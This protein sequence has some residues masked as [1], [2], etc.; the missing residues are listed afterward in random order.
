MQDHQK[1]LTSFSLTEIQEQSG[2]SLKDIQFLADIYAGSSPASLIGWGVQRYRFG[3]ENIRWINALAWQ[4][5]AIGR[6]GSGVY[7][8]VSSNHLLDFSWLGSSTN[9]SF[10][11]PIIGSEIERAEPGIDLAWITCS[12]VVNQAPDSRHVARV[13]ASIE[14][15]VVVDAFLTD[16]A[17]CADLVLPP[18]LMW[19]EEDLVGSCMHHGLQYVAPVVSPPPGARSD[20]WMVKELNHRLKAPVHLPS[21]KRCFENSLPPQAPDLETIKAQG[22]TWIEQDAVVYAQGTDHPMGRFHLI[23]TI[24]PEPPGDPEYPLRL[25]SLINK[26]FIHSQMLPAEH[27]LPPRVE[28]NPRAANVPELN[29]NEKIFLVSP[30]GRLEVDLTLDPSL[31]PGVLVYRRGDWMRLGGG[32][33]Q[34]IEASLTD[35]GVGAAYYQ[36]NVRL[37]NQKEDG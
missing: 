22:F 8:N 17:A 11:L 14:C 36:Q 31:D 24:S 12:N 27:I 15:L 9:R 5:G 33:N 1:I 21:R 32:V 10:C 19:E 30:L 20:L 35:F 13:L 23:K 28:V 3:G 26:D 37:E 34:L 25:L 16:T 4:S 6:S 7:F 2:I 18:T 29:W